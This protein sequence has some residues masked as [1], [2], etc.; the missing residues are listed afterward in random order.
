MKQ[1]SWRQIR[2]APG[3]G[4]AGGTTGV[5]MNK[6]VQNGSNGSAMTQGYDQLAVWEAAQPQNFLAADLNLQRTLEFHWGLETY[7]AHLPQ[8]YRFGH[9][10]ATDLDVAARLS[11][12][13]ENLPRLARYDGVGRRVEEVEYHPAYHQAGRLIYGS[14]AMQVYEQP[15]SNLLAL[16]LFYISSQNGEAGHN[17]PLAC[18]AGL[19]KTLQRA[20]SD[21]LKA[22]YL[23]RLLDPDYDTC[24]TGAQF[25]TE[26]QGGADVG[27]NETTATPLDPQQGVWLLNGKKWFT[28]NVTADL[29][30]VT[31]RVPGQGEGTRGLGLFLVPKV[32]E[33]GAANGMYVQRLKDKLGT[34]SLATAEIEYRDAVAYPVGEL[35]AGIHLLMNYVINTSRVYNAV[36]TSANARRAY[37]VAWTYAQHRQAFGQPILHFPLVQDGLTKMRSDSVALACGAFFIAHWL[38]EVE[39]GQAGEE[40]EAVLRTAINLNKY[41]SAEIA[42]E[43]IN[44][45]IELLG[46][47][48][49]I[50]SFSVLPRLLRDNVVF[51]NWEGPHNVLLAQAQRD[52]RRYQMHL[53]FLAR[54]RRMGGPLGTAWEGAAQLEQISAE[55]DAVLALDELTASVYFRPLMERLT[56]LFYAT[57]MAVEGAWEVAV[58]QDRSM[59]RLAEFF[60]QRRVVRRPL[61]QWPEYP[62]LVS[63][64]CADVRPGRIDRESMW[65]GYDDPMW[66]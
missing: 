55:L 53:P 28:S 44:R 10:A 23:P 21:E 31:A 4:G 43:V 5:R 50:E 49:T 12:Q 60:L 2:I 22:R 8:L 46:G 18:T 34:C 63:R 59:Q 40:A 41:R 52:F 54:L 47:N 38:D 45:G 26:V 13:K 58:K 32:L 35:K 20:G 25:V 11:N 56:D 42:H 48:G 66:E 61:A 6:T 17:C 9:V 62:E 37:L 15:A 7:R 36:G 14:G 65:E 64:L 57:R 24:F 39:R 29:A 1:C 27:A 30:L 3:A 19:I 51:E 16:A 33:D